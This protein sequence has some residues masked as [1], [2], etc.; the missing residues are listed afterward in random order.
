[1]FAFNTTVMVTVPAVAV[2]KIVILTVLYTSQKLTTI[3]WVQLVILTIFAFLNLLSGKR[4]SM[5]S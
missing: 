4:I 1:M 3:Q 5:H 2:A